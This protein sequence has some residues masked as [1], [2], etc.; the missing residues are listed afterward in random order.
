LERLWDTL[1]TIG[2]ARVIIGIL[3]PAASVWIS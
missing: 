1:S 2:R 3:L